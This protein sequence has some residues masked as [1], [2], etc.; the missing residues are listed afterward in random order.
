[1][2]KNKT[3]QS[4]GTIDDFSEWDYIIHEYIEDFY[5]K[6]NVYPNILVTS[7]KTY[8]KMND[9][10]KLFYSNE[11][12]QD[13]SY[14]FTSSKYKLRF[15]VDSGIKENSFYIIFDEAPEFDEPKKIII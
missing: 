12:I 5:K 7:E 9:H 3:K 14:Y 2:S 15:C 1:M 11:G 13:I 8:K 6:Y 10:V 4:Y